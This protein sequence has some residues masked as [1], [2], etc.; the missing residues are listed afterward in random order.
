MGIKNPDTPWAARVGATH[1]GATGQ[2]GAGKDGTPVGRS[3][4]TT[5][6]D[7]ARLRIENT[8]SNVFVLEVRTILFVFKTDRGTKSAVDQRL[9]SGTERAFRSWLLTGVPTLFCFC[10]ASSCKARL[11]TKL[12]VIDNYSQVICQIRNPDIPRAGRV[13]APGEAAGRGRAGL[14]ANRTVRTGN[15]VFL[16][17]PRHRRNVD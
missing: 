11:D 3:S 7:L 6:P 17:P 4:K 13:G 2:R 16:Y 15:N 5:T 12:Q 9:T 8:F 1:G 10:K 14:G